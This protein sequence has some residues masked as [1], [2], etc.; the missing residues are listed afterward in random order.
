MFPL[1]VVGEEEQ[2]HRQTPGVDENVSASLF[3]VSPRA[4]FIP[5]TESHWS[6][7]GVSPKWQLLIGRHCVTT[8]LSGR[9]QLV[10][11]ADAAHEAV[12]SHSLFTYIYVEAAATLAAGPAI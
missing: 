8:R 10:P 6:Q 4:P 11:H 12:R 9:L 2:N 5:S 3:I 7:G 1:G